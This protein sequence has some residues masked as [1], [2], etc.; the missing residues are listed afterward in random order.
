LN[1]AEFHIG[2]WSI[3]RYQNGRPPRQGKKKE[4][5]K[6]GV[7]RNNTRERVAD[8]EGRSSEKREEKNTDTFD[9]PE[10]MRFLERK[11]G[12]RSP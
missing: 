6:Q 10:I 7:L 5:G 3:V 8:E 11:K 4:P 1:G 9:A 2:M 12:V